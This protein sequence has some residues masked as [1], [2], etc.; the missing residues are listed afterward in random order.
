MNTVLDNENNKWL[1][2]IV[3]TAAAVV[4]LP[5]R[6]RGELKR[7]FAK[8]TK[9]RAIII[10]CLCAAAYF[11]LQIWFGM[12]LI[13]EPTWDFGFV[14]NSVRNFIL[15]PQTDLKEYAI[16][17]TR[18]PNNR[19]IV[20][21]LLSLCRLIRLFGFSFTDSNFM[22]VTVVLNC[23]F[24]N[25]AIV[26]TALVPLRRGKNAAS[27]VVLA[28]MMLNAGLLLYTPFFY[29]DTVSLFF[30]ALLIHILMNF[31]E[32]NNGI[33]NVLNAVLLAFVT[34]AA[35]NIKLTSVFIVIAYGVF[36][37][38]SR[39]FTKQVLKCAG[40][41]LI[42]AAVL[43][44]SCSAV[45][46]NAVLPKDAG[47]TFRLPASHFINMGLTGRGGFNEDVLQEAAGCESMEEAD[48]LSKRGIKDKLSAYGINGCIRF[49]RIKG[50]YTYSDGT[51]FAYEKLSRG[52]MKTDS[53][54]YRS[55]FDENGAKKDFPLFYMSTYHI[56]L[57]ALILL[58]L[59]QSLKRKEFAPVDILLI[60]FMGLFLFLMVWETRSRYL[61]NAIPVMMLIA[62]SAVFEIKMREKR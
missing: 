56:V 45:L 25:A 48:A 12:S 6:F 10:I 60:T 50:M 15:H 3:F 52:P 58:A 37:V 61:I 53:A 21:L 41:F 19:G 32:N 34:V 43:F 7:L 8:L 42:A 4:Y 51:Y 39:K 30:A 17:M 22:A 44:P 46:N 33:R 9:K 20:F 26:L 57:M 14:N 54:V 59:M 28:A 38:F 27:I 1:P 2:L 36:I 62:Q 31:S 23:V 18:Y 11:P 49:L 55:L 47:G 29:T 24:I 16:Y 35:W 13:Q 5:I 40:V